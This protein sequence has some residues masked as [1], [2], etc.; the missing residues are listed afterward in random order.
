[1]YHHVP[2]TLRGYLGQFARYGRG[3]VHLRAKWGSTPAPFRF[4]P[5]TS[6]RVLRDLIRAE[7]LV[8][9]TA[10]YAVLWLRRVALI[11]GGAYEVGGRLVQ[12]GSRWERTG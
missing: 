2:T 4:C 1:M 12:P 3:A 11:A 5:L 8:G 10:L 6:P 7:G 9:G